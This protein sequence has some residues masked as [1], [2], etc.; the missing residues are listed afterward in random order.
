MA[1]AKRHRIEP[2]S[3]VRA[4]PMRLQ[5]D[6]SQLEDLLPD[7]WAASHPEFRPDASPR[8]VTQQSVGEETPSTAAS[9][10]RPLKCVAVPMGSPNAYRLL[11]QSRHLEKRRFIDTH[12]QKEVHVSPDAAC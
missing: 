9:P 3:Y 7:H 6:D 8:R 11:H 2:W 1:G 5:A 4:L 12:L 10:I